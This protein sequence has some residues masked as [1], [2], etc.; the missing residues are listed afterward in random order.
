LAQGVLGIQLGDLSR[1]Q[2]I[3]EFGCNQAI[4]TVCIEMRLRGTLISN[5][6]KIDFTA[7]G[8]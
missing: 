5:L 6:S 1:Q 2:G 8:D 4:K 3:I 7:A